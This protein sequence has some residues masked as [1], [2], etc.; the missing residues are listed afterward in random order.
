[1]AKPLTDCRVHYQTAA[2]VLCTVMMLTHPVF[3]MIASHRVASTSHSVTV[4][5][6][7]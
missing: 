6:Y 4:H 5:M 3:E 2:L 1:V 7:H